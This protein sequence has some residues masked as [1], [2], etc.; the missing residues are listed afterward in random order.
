L[1][2]RVIRLKL[3]PEQVITFLECK[4]PVYSIVYRE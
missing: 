2:I 4:Q 3:I 1:L